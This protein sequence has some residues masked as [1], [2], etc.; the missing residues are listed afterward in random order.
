M[1]I[2]IKLVSMCVGGLISFAISVIVTKTVLR[3]GRD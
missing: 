2:L 3:K 1:R